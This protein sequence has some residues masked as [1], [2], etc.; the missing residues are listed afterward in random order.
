[1]GSGGVIG[2]GRFHGFPGGPPDT[3]YRLRGDRKSELVAMASD[4]MEVYAAEAIEAAPKLNPYQK[5]IG[6][7]ISSQRRTD[8]ESAGNRGSQLNVQFNF[9]R[10]SKAEKEGEG[11][12]DDAIEGKA[13]EIP[14]SE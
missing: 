7:G 14:D 8:W 4:V 3:G 5:V 2:E 10:R 12:G 6:Y 11:S 13:R 9:V 1:M